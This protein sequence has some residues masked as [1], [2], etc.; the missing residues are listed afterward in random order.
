MTIALAMHRHLSFLRRDDRRSE[1]TGQKPR[2][3]GGKEKDELRS[4]YG[5]NEPYQGTPR[6]TA[7]I[8]AS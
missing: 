5:S 3:K 8:I 7:R 1:S 6:R 4:N 2:D